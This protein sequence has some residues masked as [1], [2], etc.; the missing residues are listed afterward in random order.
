MCMFLDFSKAFDTVNKLDRYYIGGVINT[1]IN[2][3]FIKRIQIV[4]FN[5]NVSTAKAV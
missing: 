4:S 1:C 5:G 2:S 3:D